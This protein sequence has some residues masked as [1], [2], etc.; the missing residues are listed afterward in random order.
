MSS[1]H[2]SM[3]YDISIG[4]ERPINDVQFKNADYRGVQSKLPQL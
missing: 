4:I 1:Y 3:W 2:V